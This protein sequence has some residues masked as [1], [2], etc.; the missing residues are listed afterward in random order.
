MQ[1]FRIEIKWAFIFAGVGLA[2]MLLERL[3]GLHDRYIA[4][5]AVYTNIVAIPAIAVYVFALLDKRRNY[6]HG[7]MTFMQGFTCGLIMT[8]IIA[9]LSP[10]TQYITSTF[11]APDYFPNV[12]SYSVQEGKLTQQEAEKYFNL[13][14]YIMQGLFG[15]AIMGV[16]TSAIVALFTRTRVRTA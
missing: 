6:Y 12:I 7:T 13:K 16:L 10:L 14:S 9:I 4:Y 2:W 5:H 15:A 11:I 3:V 1:K 8:A